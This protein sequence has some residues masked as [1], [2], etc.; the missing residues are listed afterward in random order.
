MKHDGRK[1]TPTPRSAPKTG[2]RATRASAQPDLAGRRY[3]TGSAMQAPDKPG[4]P[5][6]PP[7][8]Q[9]AL[10]AAAIRM[11]DQHGAAIA[12]GA[13]R[14]GVP[15]SAAAA[16]L[17]TEGQFAA[18]AT[19]DRMPVRFEPYAFFQQTGR[20]LVATHKDQAAEYRAFQEACAIDAGAAHEALRMGIAQLSGTEAVTAGYGDAQAMMTA[21]QHDPQAQVD[22]FFL[23]IAGNDELRGAMQGEDWR[24]VA[25]LRA[26]P[27]YGALA[28]D[29]AL[30]ASADAWRKVEGGGDDDEGEPKKPKRRR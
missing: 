13:A 7:P 16:V 30:A 9:S 23:V 15:A 29:D 5:P 10:H 12:A 24:S 1:D 25:Q 20:W 2:E 6:A 28:Y 11:H 8:P 27:G 21:L 14:V 17:L 18:T 3:G 4:L 26:G 19:D 22:S